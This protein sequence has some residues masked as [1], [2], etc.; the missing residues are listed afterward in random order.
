MSSP[1]H[2]H[3][4]KLLNKLQLKGKHVF[5]ISNT[6]SFVCENDWS[7]LR[8]GLGCNPALCIRYKIERKCEGRNFHSRALEGGTQLQA[9][10]GNLFRREN[11]P[12]KNRKG[13]VSF[14]TQLV[15]KL[16]RCWDGKTPHKGSPES[17]C[18]HCNCTKT[19]DPH[20]M[21]APCELVRS[22]SDVLLHLLRPPTVLPS[23]EKMPPSLTTQKRCYRLLT[24]CSPWGQQ[25][26]PSPGTSL[27]YHQSCRGGSAVSSAHPG[28]WLWWWTRPPTQEAR[29]KWL[30]FPER[31]KERQEP[32]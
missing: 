15:P 20:R 4:V 7:L 29:G 8:S 28:R 13:E 11:A 5:R 18:S 26:L 30:C 32:G 9:L 27:G 19:Q 21:P 1:T 6:L 24:W 14:G 12:R 10:W 31:G 17:P 16:Q 23:P 22:Y 25:S 3:I 2:Q